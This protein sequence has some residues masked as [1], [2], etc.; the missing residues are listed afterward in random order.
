VSRINIVGISG[1]PSAGGTTRRLVAD[2]AGRIGAGQAEIRIV[3]VAELD[4]GARSRDEAD[5][6]LEAALQAVEGADLL[7]AGTPVYKGA[8]TGFFKQ[9]VDLVDYRA[10][11]G[12]PVALLATGGSER[13][14]LVIEHQLRPLFA[15]FQAHVLPTGVFL[16]G[17]DIEGGR[18][19]DPLI[20]QRLDRLVAEANA[21][22]V[23][24]ALAAY[25]AA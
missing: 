2:V 23:T 18:I 9:F 16:T 11:A 24:P 8:Y 22:L 14:A 7:V 10:L 19:T 12:T 4:L 25:A 20:A 13:H 6:A 3:D 15:F 21:A 17:R 1:S 5:A